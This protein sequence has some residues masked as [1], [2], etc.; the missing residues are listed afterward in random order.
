MYGIF[1][2]HGFEHHYGIGSLNGVAHLDID[3]GEIGIYG[4]IFAMTHY[5][6]SVAA[7]IL[8]EAGYYSV[9]Y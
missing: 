2:L 6:E 4:I 8:H 7:G 3:G 9:E 5:Y 1:H